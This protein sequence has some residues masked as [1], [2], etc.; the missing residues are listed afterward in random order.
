MSKH[1]N[2][3]NCIQFIDENCIICR[4]NLIMQPNAVL[5]L[6]NFNNQKIKKKNLSQSFHLVQ[7]YQLECL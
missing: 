7:F 5:K 1:F 2:N 3:Q 6:Q 4:D